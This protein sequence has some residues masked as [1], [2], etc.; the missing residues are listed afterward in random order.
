[1]CVHAPLYIRVK[2]VFCG[3]VQ[4][5]IIGKYLKDKHLRILDFRTNVVRRV[6]PRYVFPNIIE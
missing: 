6:R 3:T 1:M 5:D 2:S 4:C